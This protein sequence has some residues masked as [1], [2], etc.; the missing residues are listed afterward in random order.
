MGWETHNKVVIWSFLGNSAR[1]FLV[2]KPENT[3]FLFKSRSA[4]V[5]VLVTERSLRILRRGY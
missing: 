1:I 3:L 2:E 4:F 5:L